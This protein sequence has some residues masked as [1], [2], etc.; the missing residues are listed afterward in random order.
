[1]PTAP[2]PAALWGPQTG[3]VLLR[4]TPLVISSASLMFSWA[5]HLFFG[6]FVNSQ[7]SAQPD[8]PAGKVLVHYMPEAMRRGVPAIL[9]LYPSAMAL[10]FANSLG[11]YKVVHPVARR[12]YLASG[13][14]SLAHFYFVPRVK[15][16]VAAISAAKDPG[17]R[18]EDAMRD[19]L[20]MHTQRSLLVNFPA[21]LCLF[22]G[23]VLVVS[24][25]IA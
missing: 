24:E 16:I 6:N 15:R 19:W 18:N 5:Q 20:A 7:L 4:L 2:T 21:W 3:L 23:T 12:F 25:G 17:V 11:G 22:V 14:L 8:H 1:M 9:A 13:V 10:A